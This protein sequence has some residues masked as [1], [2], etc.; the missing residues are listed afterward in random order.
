[1][2]RENVEFARRLRRRQTDAEAALWP[3]L[4]AGQ[5][6]GFKFRRQH[7][8]GPYV[9][10]FVCLDAQP[11][12]EADGSQHGTERDATR[13]AFLVA[14]GFR[15]LRFWDNDVLLDTDVVMNA[16]WNALQERVDA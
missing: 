8:I 1:V 7:P 5:V 2:K 11:V 6:P 12:V 10:D 4:R 13:D 15:V 9:V 14:Q 3:R 16:I